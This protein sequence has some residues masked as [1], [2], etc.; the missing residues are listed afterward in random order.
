MEAATEAHVIRKCSPK[1][2]LRMA[3]IRVSSGL[4]GWHHSPYSTSPDSVVPDRSK[5]VVVRRGTPLL[6]GPWCRRISP[7]ISHPR[8]LP[9]WG[10][11]LSCQPQMASEGKP[12]F[13]ELGSGSAPRIQWLS[14]LGPTLRWRRSRPQPRRTS[15][16]G[17]P[18]G[19]LLDKSDGIVPPG[20]S[21]DSL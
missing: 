17:P 21:W 4:A 14:Q 6:S 1:L 19:V 15:G 20:T 12:E 18:A 8:G 3:L 16:S 7:C 10:I 9:G 13:P 2:G 5:T 11:G